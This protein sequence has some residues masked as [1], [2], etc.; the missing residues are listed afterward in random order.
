[1]KNYLLNVF[2]LVVAVTS[3]PLLAQ[4]SDPLPSWNDGQTKQ[5]I[6]QFVSNVTDPDSPNFVEPQDRIATFD[7]DGTL[8]SEKPL[9]SQILFVL[10]QIKEQA[11]NNPGWKTTKPY[12]LVLSGQIDKLNLEDVLTMVQQTHS[13]MSSDEFTSIVQAWISTAK[14]PVTGQRYTDMVYQPMLELLDYLD[15]NG[16]KNF[17]VSG[18]SN[19]FMRAW[20]TD[21]YNIPSERII[22]TRLSTEFVN[23][24]GDYQ[25]KRIPGIDVNDDK[26]EKPQQIYQHIGKRPIASFGN[27]DGDLQMMQWT[28]SGTGPH[29]AMYVHHTDG[30]RE[31]NYGRQDSLAKLDKGLDEAKAKGWLIADMKND[32]KQVYPTK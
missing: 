27:S 11:A 7:N 3:F 24:D 21:A 8:W 28:T 30:Q 2:T 25:V 22:G 10:D 17:I 15:S 23:V 6:I 29:L 12:S 14:H 20:A 26:A 19:A 4:K 5:A 1:M 16:F 13:G 18:G 31:W 9:P 32:W